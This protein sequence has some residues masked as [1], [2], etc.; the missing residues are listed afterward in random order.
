MRPAQLRRRDTAVPE[1][2]RAP[3]VLYVELRSGADKPENVS[4][5]I[6]YGGSTTG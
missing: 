4:C 5:H 6:H 2:G 1:A 3:V